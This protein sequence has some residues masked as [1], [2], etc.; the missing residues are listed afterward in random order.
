MLLIFAAQYFTVENINGLKTGNRDAAV[1]FTI[2]NRLQEIVSTSAYLQARL[3]KGNR[4]NINAETIYDSLAVMGYNASVLEKLNI[5]TATKNNFIKLNALINRQVDLGFKLLETLEKD[6]LNTKKRY[7]DSLSG[8][9]VSDSILRI[10]IDIGKQLEIKLTKTFDQNSEASQKISALNKIFALIA[11][12]AI[13][14]LGTIIIS[15]HRRQQAL[16][17]ALKH[18]NEEVKKSAMIKDQFLANMSH[19]LRTP[20]NAI[21]GFTLLL[22]QTGLNE[23]QK[24]FSG[25]IHDSSNNL[26]HLVNDILDISKIVSGEMPVDK[27]EFDLKRMFQTLES[28]FM[29]TIGEKQLKYTWNIAAD[30]PQYL[31]GDPD[32]I[33]QILVNLVSNACKFTQKGS[34]HLDVSKHFEDENIVELNFKV[35]DTGIGIPET[36]HE[37]I[38]E[39]FQQIENPDE[40]MPKGTGLGLAIVKNL[41][42]L[43]GGSVSVASEVE[44]GSVFNVKLPFT[45]HLTVETAG[46]KINEIQNGKLKFKDAQVLVAED[47]PVNQ[48]L[49]TRLLKHYEIEPVIKENGIEVLEALKTGHFNLLLLDI[50][51]PLLDGY[52]TCMAIRETGNM[53]PVVAMTAYVMEAEKEK[54]SAAGMNDYLAKPIEE[55]KLKHIL[56]K[57]LAL[58]IDTAEGMDEIDNNAFL[59]EL[60]GGD[61]QMAQVI[62]KQVKEELLLEIA[63]LKKIISE[64]NIRDL[65]AV[66]HHLVS[67][68]SPL[69]NDSLA[70]RKIQAVQKVVSEGGPE[71]EILK[72]T[73]DLAEELEKNYHELEPVK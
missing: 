14:V 59:L 39:R 45:K 33:Y 49:I 3:I 35:E 47:N 11:V 50:Q 30:V 43:L 27:K 24:K 17:R 4:D 26:L 12:F 65:P 71:V 46:D 9:H 1:T 23:E 10:A 68:I 61:K 36:K 62:L 32:R 21:K 19:E 28:M 42:E 63:K 41:T 16:I 20:L 40:N 54:C 44:K 70:I 7:A 52:K 25:I 15:R 22:Q 31:N 37:L 6:D 58:F 56:Q 64:K 60:A 69:G 72:R 51:M 55:N 57:Y 29:N 53:M 48:Q 2:N 34:I 73:S 67:S 5:D 66:C 8:L 38:F 18:A 13:L